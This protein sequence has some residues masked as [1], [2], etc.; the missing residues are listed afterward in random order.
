[1]LTDSP[2]TNQPVGKTFSFAIGALG[3]GAILQLLLIGYAFVN[4]AR[5][6]VPMVAV[7]TFAP[8]NNALTHLPTA[9]QVP[10]ESLDLNS[11]P[12]SEP[13]QTIAANAAATPPKPT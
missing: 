5:L 3:V 8:A 10:R 9:I 12:I 6:G 2:I 1:M 11:N 4:R 13:S 7:A